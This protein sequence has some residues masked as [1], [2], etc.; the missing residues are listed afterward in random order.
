MIQQT[1]AIFEDGLLKPDEE[2]ALTP[3]ER[4]RVVISPLIIPDSSE[5]PLEELDRVC[6]EIDLNS[7]GDWMTREELHERR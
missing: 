7:G 5:S 2:L 1:T 3:G 6:D 4:V